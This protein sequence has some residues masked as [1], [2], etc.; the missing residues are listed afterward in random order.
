[1]IAYASRHIAIL[2][3]AVAVA[4]GCAAHMRASSPIILKRLQLVSAGHTGCLPEANE[5][6]NVTLSFDGSGIW[7]ATCKATTY[8]CTTVGSVGS[9][10]SFSCAPVAQ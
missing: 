1:M 6:S 9:S 5:I 4:T 8:L 7:N 2:A 3:T 10:E